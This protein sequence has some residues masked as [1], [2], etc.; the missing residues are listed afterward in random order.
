MMDDVDVQQT[1]PYNFFLQELLSSFTEAERRFFDRYVEAD[2]PSRFNL[3]N[4]VIKRAEQFVE[5]AV[6]VSD[7]VD[8]GYLRTLLDKRMKKVENNGGT[9]LDHA[10]RASTIVVECEGYLFDKG[11]LI[12]RKPKVVADADL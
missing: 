1:L 8:H 10:Q 3:Y 7:K 11:F 4:R 5:R 6:K 2:W 12:S 9:L